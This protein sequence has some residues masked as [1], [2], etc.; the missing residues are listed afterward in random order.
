MKK[1]ANNPYFNSSF[2]ALAAKTS[3]FVK[4]IIRVVGTPA[5]IEKAI[6]RYA[7]HYYKIDD[8]FEGETL[9]EYQ[10]YMRKSLHLYLA[11]NIGLETEETKKMSYPETNNY[12]LHLRD[13]YDKI[14]FDYMIENK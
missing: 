6:E 11:I 9:E 8:E 7:T 4:E 2:D 5:N 3:A 1:S 13:K 14:F 12:L 10:E